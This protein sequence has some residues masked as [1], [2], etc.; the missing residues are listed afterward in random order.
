MIIDTDNILAKA[1]S[2][3]DGLLDL[4]LRSVYNAISKKTTSVVNALR[5]GKIAYRLAKD[6]QQPTQS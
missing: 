6:M 3:K 1:K 4:S 5:V 2:V